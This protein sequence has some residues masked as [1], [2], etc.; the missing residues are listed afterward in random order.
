MKTILPIFL[1]LVL[2]SCKSKR[3][4]KKQEKNTNTL[5]KTSVLDIKKSMEYLASDELK[6]RNTGSKGIEKAAVFIENY[7]TFFTQHLVFLE[8][9]FIHHG[10]GK[11]Y[12]IFLQLY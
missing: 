3:V 7:L 11:C 5:F 10:G 2:V 9:L 12:G 1:L 6:G 4:D 8:A